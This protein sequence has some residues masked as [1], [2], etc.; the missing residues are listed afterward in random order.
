MR[1]TVTLEPEVE[2]LLRSAMKEQGVSFKVALNSAIRSG[3]T[4]AR[5]RRRF[6]QAA[7]SMGAEQNFRWDQ[8]LAAA[9]A[10]EDEEIA[11]K[12]AVRK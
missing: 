7:F 12:L 11:R 2:A 10:L 1:T 3:L 6:V 4:A 8:A 5:P 9:E